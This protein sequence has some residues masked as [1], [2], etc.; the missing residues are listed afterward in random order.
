MDKIK[1][2]LLIEECVHSKELAPQ[3]ECTCHLHPPCWACT[4]PI[5]V[6]V[7]CGEEFEDDTEDR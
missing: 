6:C 1:K 2:L 7:K 4:N 3:G 5:Y